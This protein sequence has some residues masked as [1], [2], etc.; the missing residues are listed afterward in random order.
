MLLYQR[1]RYDMDCGSTGKNQIAFVSRGRQFRKLREDTRQGGLPGVPFVLRK[2][3]FLYAT[4]L[5]IITLQ[6]FYFYEIPVCF[7][8][9]LSIAQHDSM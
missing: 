7:V 6:L 2:I 4:G 1:L 8:E 9:N 3:S 5:R